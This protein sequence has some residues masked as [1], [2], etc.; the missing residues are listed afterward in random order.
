[1]VRRTS[2]AFSAIINAINLS[3]ALVE[4]ESYNLTLHLEN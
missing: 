1:M 2:K 4:R 3:S